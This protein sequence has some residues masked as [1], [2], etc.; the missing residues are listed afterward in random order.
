MSGRGKL[1]ADG[2]VAVRQSAQR[3]P[4]VRV[5]AVDVV[6][7]VHLA[8]DGGN[9]IV[10]VAGEHAGLKQARLFAAV[11]HRSILVAH[12]PLRMRFER[13]CPS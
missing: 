13:I 4:A 8:H 9:V 12:R 11:L 1:A 10:H 5:E 3:R 2:A 7:R 6:E